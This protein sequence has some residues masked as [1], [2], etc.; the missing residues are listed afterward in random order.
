MWINIF[1]FQFPVGGRLGGHGVLAL[2][3]VDMEKDIEK[4][5]L[6]NMLVMVVHD[7]LEVIR[8]KVHVVLEDIVQDQVIIVGFLP[9]ALEI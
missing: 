1:I 4:G 5:A 9:L 3:P 2:G 7:V 8:T 6:S